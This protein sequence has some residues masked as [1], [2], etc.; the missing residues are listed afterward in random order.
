MF[1]Y[2]VFFISF[3]ITSSDKADTFL[4]SFK[5]KKSFLFFQKEKDLFQYCFNPH[6]LTHFSI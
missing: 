1:L 5:Y 2:T 4:P 6:L 3:V